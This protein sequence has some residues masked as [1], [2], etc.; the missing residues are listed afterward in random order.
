MKMLEGERPIY[1]LT[2]KTLSDMADRQKRREYFFRS[3]VRCAALTLL[4][5][6][7][8]CFYYIYRREGGHTAAV[9]RFSDGAFDIRGVL[10][11]LF[12]SSLIPVLGLTSCFAFGGRISRLCDTLLPA[13]YGAYSGFAL[14]DAFVRLSASFTVSNTV[15]S[16]PFI[17]YT[18]GV[19]T[20][21]LLFCPVCAAFGECRRREKA[22][23]GDIKYCTGCFF[24]ALTALTALSLLEEF[25]VFILNVLS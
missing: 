8:G 20:V 12:F 7:A 11:R 13:L 17:L 19:I 18:V 25:F 24:A 1:A 3:A 16:L 5:I 22:D 2:E 6:A 21:Y 9:F 4:F 10:K 23:D 15:N 14:F